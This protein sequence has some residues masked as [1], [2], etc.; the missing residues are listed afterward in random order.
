MRAG[1]TTAGR[2]QQSGMARRKRV[3]LG[4]M[5]QETASF[6]P[7]PTGMK[8]WKRDTG[9]R[10]LDEY[11]GT[12]TEVGAFI[13]ELQQHTSEIEIVPT[14]A[15]DSVP[16][17]LIPTADLQSLFDEMLG[18]IRSAAAAGPVA[19]VLLCLHGAMAGETEPDPEGVLLRHVRD[20]IGDAT[21]LVVSIDLHCVLTPAMIE[22]ADVLVPFHTYPHVDQYETGQR[23]ARCL[24]RLLVGGTAI[25]RPEIVRL[26]LPMLVRG[27][28]LITG[29]TPTAT[30]ATDSTAA[31][32]GAAAA[33]TY[34]PVVGAFGH[35]IQMCQE[36]EA[37]QRSPATGAPCEHLSVMAAGVTIGNAFTDVP[38]L[39]SN[40][41]VVFRPLDSTP[42]VALAARAEAEQAAAAIGRHMWE[43]RQRFQAELVSVDDA[44]AAARAEIAITNGVKGPT[45]SVLSD[46]ADATASGASGD[47]NVIL[48]HAMQPGAFSGGRLLL[49]IVA[50]EAVAHATA[51][52]VGATGLTLSL[53]GSS[54]PERFPPLVC[55]RVSVKRL[56]DGHFTY[57]NQTS[58]FAGRTVV[59]QLELPAAAAAAG[60][61]GNAGGAAEQAAATGL[62]DIV[63]CER[64]AYFVGQACFKAF[65]CDPAEYDAVVVKSPNGFRQYYD[66]ISQSIHAVDCPGSTSANLRSLPFAHVRRPI[67]P[68]DW[69]APPPRWMLV[70]EEEETAAVAVASTARL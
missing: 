56:Y 5:V 26:E 27:D 14:F 19:G 18:A 23:A 10:L 67:F 43:H 15:A 22:L 70:A 35:A 54:D 42:A 37:L 24:L 61:G 29:R 11:T 36:L 69:D 55:E 12:S 8:M 48:R 21:P 63:A 44:L 33:W 4:K 58:G 47:S 16:G 65:G 31:G 57:E 34:S 62:V 53:G 25:C 46:A 30:A 64:A 60:P 39:Q 17:G 41:F 7:L 68:L 32:G 45:V 20:I 13:D 38:E 49:P 50:P 9:E 59:L 3:L 51:A 66:G 40:V 1:G 6:N 52:G 2:Q 28:E